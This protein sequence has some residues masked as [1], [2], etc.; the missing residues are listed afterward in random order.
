MTTSDSGLRFGVSLDPGVPPG[1]TFALA[2]AAEAA[3]LDLV[4]VQDHPYQPAHL[5]TWTLVTALGLRTSRIGVTTDVADLALRPPALL[6]KAAATLAVLTGGR[7]ELG[8]G[9]G[10]IP[11]GIASM[12]GRRR[13]P[14]ETVAFT[15]ESLHILRFAFAGQPVRLVSDQ[16]AIE[17]YTP[18][19][20]PERPPGLWLG[21]Q[22]PRM[23][24]VA[25]RA[26]DGWVCPLNIYVPPD[27]VPP[28]Q[29]I[30]DNAARA[31]GR[32]PSDVRRVYNVI[33]TIGRQPH[34]PGIT[35]DPERWADTLSGWVMD[36]GFDTF[37]FWPVADARAQI[38]AFAAE[39]VPGVRARV[40]AANATGAGAG[41]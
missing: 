29:R 37:V 22:F 26:A 41:R 3:G 4:A 24:A 23:L 14:A 10:G 31:A 33:G 36:L 19:P 15:E 17:G 39:V 12:G 40:A 1:E 34:G 27:E 38:E 5:D 32:M 8:V 20:V 35:G 25:G 30:V 9:G 2:A 6:A 13:S 18:G 11:D 28:R 16:H 7:F 21:A